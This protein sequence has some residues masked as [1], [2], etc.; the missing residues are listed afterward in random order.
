MQINPRIKIAINKMILVP[1]LLRK[2]TKFKNTMTSIIA[3]LIIDAA[4]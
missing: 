3:H 4:R 2:K 1:S